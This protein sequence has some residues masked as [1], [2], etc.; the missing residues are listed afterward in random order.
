MN[1]RLKSIRVQR[2][3][4][5]DEMAKKLNTTRSIYLEYEKG[6]RELRAKH[7]SALASKLEVDI[8]WFLGLQRRSDGGWEERE[9]EMVR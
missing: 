6:V 3:L 4:T 8:Y 7:I 1:K 2:G 9:E 5:R